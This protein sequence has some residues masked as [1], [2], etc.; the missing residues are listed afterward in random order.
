MIW[1]VANGFAQLYDLCRYP[2]A[3]KR[4]SWSNCGPRVIFVR[5]MTKKAFIIK[6]LT[7]INN[8]NNNK[9]IFAYKYSNR[10]DIH[11]LLYLTHSQG[12]SDQDVGEAARQHGVVSAL[13][14]LIYF[15]SCYVPNSV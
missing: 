8:N 10:V 5:L 14:L 11:L 6:A 7:M 15:I 9:M 1:T 3:I 2:T 4:F 12:V 13:S